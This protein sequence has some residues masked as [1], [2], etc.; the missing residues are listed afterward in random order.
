[1]VLFHDLSQMLGIP[2]E[3]ELVS[4]WPLLPSVVFGWGRKFEAPKSEGTRSLGMGVL[5]PSPVQA[6]YFLQHYL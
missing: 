3:N 6:G 1:M 4:Y 2:G 5:G